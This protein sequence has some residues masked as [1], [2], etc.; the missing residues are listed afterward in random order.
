[1]NV[2]IQISVL[3]IVE[4]AEKM[5]YQCERGTGMINATLDNGRS[6]KQIFV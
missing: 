3:E 6:L 5:V 1:M 2:Q 4:N